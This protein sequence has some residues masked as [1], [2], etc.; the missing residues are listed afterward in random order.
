LSEDYER[1]A[2]LSEI[3]IEA[4]MIRLILRQLARAAA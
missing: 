2:Q 4:A 3:F 1:M